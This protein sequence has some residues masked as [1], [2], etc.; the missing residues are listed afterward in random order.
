MPTPRVAT[1]FFF[2]D[3]RQEVGNKFSLMGVFQSDSIITPIKPPVAFPKFGLG[4]WLFS[5][6]GDEPSDFT[7]RLLGPPNRTELVRITLQPLNL[8]RLPR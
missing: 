4:I 5:D 6:I 7:I 3:V 1:C 2:E 8:P